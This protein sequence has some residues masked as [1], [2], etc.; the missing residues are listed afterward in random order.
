M[1]SFQ[2]GIV[3]QSIVC[4]DLVISLSR[5]PQSRE[6]CDR[7]RTNTYACRYLSDLNV[8]EMLTL[9]PVGNAWS[10]YIS[11]RFP[12]ISSPSPRLSS[13]PLQRRRP[14]RSASNLRPLRSRLRGQHPPG[15]I[16]GRDI[17]ARPLADRSRVNMI[18]TLTNSA[19][20]VIA[21]TAEQSRAGWALRPGL[22]RRCI[23]RNHRETT[24]AAMHPMALCSIKASIV[25][26]T[27]NVNHPTQPS[28]L[29]PTKPKYGLLGHSK[30][31][32]LQ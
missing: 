8:N 1:L 5:R 20:A 4:A 25:E 17:R 10:R 30:S 29:G 22:P 15:A 13:P 2:G 23:P 28:C 16:S 14:R 3:V 6:T 19:F 32:W 27:T 24:Q 31:A 26:R 12:R 7:C 9:T 11:S 21:S 18:R